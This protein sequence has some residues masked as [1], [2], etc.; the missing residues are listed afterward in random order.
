MILFLDL[1][2][3]VDQLATENSVRWCGHVL[4]KEVSHVLRKE[5]GH[6]LGKALEYEVECQKK[7][8]MLKRTWKR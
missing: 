6:V 4:R 2:D 8:V 7:I 1:N 5:V 3:T